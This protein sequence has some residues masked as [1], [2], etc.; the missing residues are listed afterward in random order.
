MENKDSAPATT[1]SIEPATQ[2]PTPMPQ[3][4]SRAMVGM[5]P[6]TLEEGWRYA[7][8]IAGS[9]LA[10]KDY[11]GKPENVLVAM[12]MGAEVGLA[13]M[14]A[15]QNIAVINGRPSIWGDAAL[16]IVQVDK[17]YVTHHEFF[18]G[19][20]DTKTAVF[21]ISRKGHEPYTV[22]FSVADAKKAGLWGKA[23]PWTN[24]PDRMLQMRARGFGLRDKFADALRGLSIAEEVQD[25]PIIEASFSPDARLADKSKDRLNDAM[26]RATL[27]PASEEELA[28][29]AKEAQEVLERRR[30]E[31]KVADASPKQQP[32]SPAEQVPETQSPHSGDQH[33]QE[34][35][36]GVQLGFDK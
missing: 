2:T 19:T 30:A 16:G 24:Y 33:S 31:E 14:A 1:Q 5:T 21:T 13:P 23:G 8:L 17:S 35:P 32:T 9:E 10:P 4:I 34:Q 28:R 27:S 22:R 36:Q 15:I 7:K 3:P 25:I 29:Q 26:N 11:K 18:E 6:T 12:Q 20:G